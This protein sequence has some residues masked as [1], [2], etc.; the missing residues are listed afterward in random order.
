[1]K[2]MK[3][4]LLMMLTGLLVAACEKPVLGEV[5]DETETT[6]M[7]GKKSSKK[8]TFTVKGD[9]GLRRSLAATCKPTGRI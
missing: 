1:M 7:W 6:E 2:I 9:S 3:K 4:M 5:E 8:F